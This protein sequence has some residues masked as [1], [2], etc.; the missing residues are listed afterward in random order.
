MKGLPNNLIQSKYI[1][2]IC[3]DG[4][5]QKLLHFNYTNKLLFSICE[6]FQAISI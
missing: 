1:T 3:S 4:T 5:L 6:P 2:L